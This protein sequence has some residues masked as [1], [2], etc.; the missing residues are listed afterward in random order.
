MQWK[1]KLASAFIVL[2]M[3]VWIGMNTV[4]NGVEEIHGP[5]SETIDQAAVTQLPELELIETELEQDERRNAA[6][7]LNEPWNTEPRQ[8]FMEKAA[9]QTGE[10]VQRTA[11]KS[12]ETLVAWFESATD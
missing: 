12:L 6:M 2:V 1:G 8:S 10:L 5:F 9:D 7:K 3:G 11:H 4:T